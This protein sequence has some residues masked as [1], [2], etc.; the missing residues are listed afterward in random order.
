MG[1]RQICIWPP[2]QTTKPLKAN[3]EFWIREALFVSM[4][5][6]GKWQGHL[7]AGVSTGPR[8]NHF[9]GPLR[10][11]QWETRE[12]RRHLCPPGCGRGR[13]GSSQH[14]WSCQ[15]HAPILGDPC[16]ISVCVLSQPV[17]GPSVSPEGN[18]RGKNAHTNSPHQL[19]S[20][21]PVGVMGKE[22][23]NGVSMSSFC[24]FPDTLA[25]PFGLPSPFLQR[26]VLTRQKTP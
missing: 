4:L 15:P 22:A 24:V 7:E 21:A 8:R 2:P 12:A 20:P 19:V 16:P 17:W 25:G 3:L 23:Q 6:A 1:K 14:E 26:A 5:V 9:G 10:F 11:G 18:R 13:R